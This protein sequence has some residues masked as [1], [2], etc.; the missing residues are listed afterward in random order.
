MPGETTAAKPQNKKKSQNKKKNQEKETKAAEKD[1]A[2]AVAIAAQALLHIKRAEGNSPATKK[3]KGKG[4][5]KPRVK[6]TDQEQAYLDQMRTDLKDA[7]LKFYERQKKI[8]NYI[9]S[10]RDARPPVVQ[11][12]KPTS[13]EN[14]MKRLRNLVEKQRELLTEYKGAPTDSIADNILHS[15][16]KNAKERGEVAKAG[17][18]GTRDAV[19]KE[20]LE[21]MALD[22]ADDTRKFEQKLH[23]IYEAQR[24]ESKAAMSDAEKRARRDEGEY[25]DGVVHELAQYRQPSF[26]GGMGRR[27]MLS[28]W[29]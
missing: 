17:A 14:A 29:G 8:R 22:A 6:L 26:G 28:R 1:L 9:K 5:K 18:A 21:A 4:K 16:V 19:S 11:Q 20:K 13:A 25:D 3:G 2:E 15:L 7:G 24:D 27:A 12:V 10:I 23:D